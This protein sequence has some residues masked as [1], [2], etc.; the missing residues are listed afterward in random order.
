MS[1]YFYSHHHLLGGYARDLAAIQRWGIVRTLQTQNVAEH[2]YY[3]VLYTVAICDAL[4]VDGDARDIATRLAL[5]HDMGE[6]LSGD[7][8]SPWRRH[9]NQTAAGSLGSTIRSR[10][11][12]DAQAGP[13]PTAIVKVADI[14]EAAM[15][16]AQEN[17]LGNQS[18]REVLR[19]LLGKLDV[20]IE[21]LKV[22]APWLTP[23]VVDSL[24]ESLMLN[25]D[26]E[27]DRATEVF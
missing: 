16:L 20:A 24:R 17:S 3:V 12:S 19:D 21:G 26:L 2:S 8:P 18:V 9:I 7:I 23:T 5:T 15:F 14:Y 25:V 10:F 1:L 4:G 22:A 13:V 6:T 11:G 27:R